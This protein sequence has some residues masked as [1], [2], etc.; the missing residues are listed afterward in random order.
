M[1]TENKSR[2][3]ACRMLS[4]V[5]EDVAPEV[6]YYNIIL[7]AADV[8]FDMADAGDLEFLDRLR[9]LAV[10]AVKLGGS[11]ES[12]LPTDPDSRGGNIETIPHH[13]PPAGILF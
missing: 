3:E 12:C 5:K 8:I 4:L 2:P 10:L 7:I 6:R 13:Y 1:K 9:E 11:P